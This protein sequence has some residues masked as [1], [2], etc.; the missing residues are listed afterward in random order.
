VWVAGVRSARWNR[1]PAVV[2]RPWPGGLSARPA[3][4][5]A[6]RGELDRSPRPVSRVDAALRSPHPSR[7]REGRGGE[8]RGGTRSSSGRGAPLEWARGPQAV[9]DQRA[10]ATSPQ[11]GPGF[12]GR[13]LFF[14]PGRVAEVAD[15]PS[16]QAVERDCPCPKLPVASL[17]DPAASTLPP[18][19]SR[20]TPAPTPR[21]GSSLHPT[22][23]PSRSS[24]GCHS[25]P[26]RS[27]TRVGSA[28]Q[29][30]LCSSP[31]LDRR[32]LARCSARTGR[33]SRRAPRS[34]RRCRI[35]SPAPSRF[36]S[37]RPDRSRSTPPSRRSLRSHRW[38]G[39]RGARSP[40]RSRGQE[41]RSRSLHGPLGRW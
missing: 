14:V 31:R 32:R 15:S 36:L 19:A 34:R 13:V 24:S 29:P 40:R 22:T 5:C 33:I 7:S 18:L 11:R 27:R 20:S 1:L 4:L 30:A 38:P 21:G 9:H 28:S 6:I 10:R 23:S 8:G 37:C 41:G 26:E 2:Q 39:C 3:G 17:P 12:P 35:P 16:P 25:R